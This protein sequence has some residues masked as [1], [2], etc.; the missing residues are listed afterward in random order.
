ML[1]RLNLSYPNQQSITH[2]NWM[3]KSKQ[4]TENNF[5]TTKKV[6]KTINNHS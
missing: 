1:L 2:V 3:E 6:T 5:L 4:Q